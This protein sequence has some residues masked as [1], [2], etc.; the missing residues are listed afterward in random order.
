M[1]I[2]DLINE[3]SDISEAPFGGIRK[4]FRN[5]GA[6]IASAV[7]GSRNPAVRAEIRNRAEALYD[8]FDEY[9]GKKRKTLPQATTA[10]LVKFLEIKQVENI[11]N[12]QI[13]DN[14]L[15]NKNDVIELFSNII[16]DILTGDSPT[17]AGDTGT[18][19]DPAGQPG[20]L[21]QSGAL[22]GTP[23]LKKFVDNLTDQQRQSLINLLSRT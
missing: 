22:D 9:L 2:R 5:I 19:P 18:P 4:A 15:S 14:I 23:K 11:Q 17:P 8:D 7:T 21:G 1:R 3:D 13:P 20:P 6:G 12:Y 10:D 16:S